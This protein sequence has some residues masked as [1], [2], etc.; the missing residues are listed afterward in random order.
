MLPPLRD[1]PFN[2]YRPR[3]YSQAE[4]TSEIDLA[5]YR[6]ASRHPRGSHLPVMDAL[7]R[8]LHDHAIDDALHGHLAAR[9]VVAVM[10]GHT[11]GAR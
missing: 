9:E 6:W 11:P 8:R 4:L 5:I 7:A 2:P 1:L 10:G 3:L